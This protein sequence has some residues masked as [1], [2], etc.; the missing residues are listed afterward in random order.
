MSDDKTT[1][2]WGTIMVHK[3]HGQLKGIVY[4]NDLPYPGETIFKLKPGCDGKKTSDFWSEHW[5]IHQ[6]EPVKKM[7]KGNH[8]KDVKSIWSRWKLWSKLPEI[9]AH[10]VMNQVRGFVL[11]KNDKGEI[12]FDSSKKETKSLIGQMNEPKVE[13]EKKQEDAESSDAALQAHFERGI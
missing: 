7:F 6:T 5:C 2:I 1:R 11:L 12:V 10:A 3:E 13:E 8:Y 4:W 9:Y